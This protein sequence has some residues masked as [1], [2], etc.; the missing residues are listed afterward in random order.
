MKSLRTRITMMTLCVVLIAVTVITT[1]TVVFIRKNEHHKSD[2]LMLVLCET[3][4][5]NLNYYFNSVQNSVEKVASF[6]EADIDG[7][8]DE[9][10]EQH[11]NRVGKYF[12]EMASK[13]NGVLTYYYRIDPTISK[14]VKGFWFTDLDGE[15]FV[16]HEVTDITLYDTSDTSKL[17]WFTVP[18]YEGESIWLPPYITD[19]LNKRVISYNV[20]IYYR[21]QFIGVVGIEI[22]YSTMAEQVDSIRLFNSG[23][24]FLSDSEGNLFYHPKIDVTQLTEETMPDVPDGLMSDSTYIQY[25]FEGIEK[26]AAWLPL[27]NGMRLNVCAPLSESEGDWQA[28]IMNIL[29]VAIEVLLVSSLFTLFY[30]KRISSPLKQLISAADEVDKGNFEI[31]LDYDK[32]D[33]IGRLTK[34]FKRM[35]EHMDDHISNLNREVYV[36]ALTRVKNKGAYSEII[37]EI[38][39]QIDEGTNPVEF[40]FGVFDCDDLKRINDHYGHDKGD[41]YLR[42]ACKAICNVFVH[43]PVFRIGGDEFAVVLRDEEYKNIDTLVQQF[44]KSTSRINESAEKEWE[45]VNISFG[46]AVYDKQRDTAVIDVARRAD[47]N[48]YDNKRERKSNIV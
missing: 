14:N 12:D 11:V 40:A 19:N 44:E 6:A 29:V 41:I 4:E 10:L 42:T 8:E 26:V 5:R 37:R 7:L 43:S 45:K 27:S 48:M 3:G 1:L 20:P 28:L 9:Q 46:M 23:Y 34:T 18:K 21:G 38:Q 2:Q 24:A 47:R 33:E 13:A 15:G 39:S 25:K 31:S 35:A 32:D 16:S 36:D 30:T 22:D 17:V